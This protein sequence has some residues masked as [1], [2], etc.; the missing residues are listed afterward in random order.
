MKSYEKSIPEH[1]IERI[2][3]PPPAI[4]LK[5]K[6]TILRLRSE[7]WSLLDIAKEIGRLYSTVWRYA[8]EA[9]KRAS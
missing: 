2:P 4:P 5:E 1:L 8:T 9:K 6:L 3:F 7:G